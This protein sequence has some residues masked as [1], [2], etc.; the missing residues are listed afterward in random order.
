MFEATIGAMDEATRALFACPSEALVEEQARI[1][2]FQNG[3]MLQLGGQP[4]IL[5]YSVA[6]D[7]WE[8]LASGWQPGDPPPLEGMPPPPEGLYLPGEQFGDLWRDPRLQSLLGFA[9]APEPTGFPAVEQEFPGG[10]LVGDRDTGVVYPFV[11]S[12]QR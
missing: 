11:A 7:R 1:L 10:L 6:D 4:D 5:I 8:R 9:L 12:K 2:S 3:Y